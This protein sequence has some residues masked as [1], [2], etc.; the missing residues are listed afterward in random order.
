[1]AARR[2][3]V[4]QGR[5]GERR[6]LD[7]LLQ[8]VRGGRSAALVIRGEA[9][10]GKTALLRHC[11]R[12]ASG[13]HVA[14]IAGVESEMELAFAGLHQLCA[15]ML[16]R[17]DALAE[18]QQDA[19][20]VAL[21]L[22]SGDAPNRFLVALATLGL[23]AEEAADRPL[24]CVVDDAQW[25]DAASRQ[26]LGFV[27]RRLQAEAV[28]MV[29]AVRDP[30]GERDL[31]G[32]PELRLEGLPTEDARALLAAVIP[33]GLDDRV[34]DRL[35][36]ETRGN[37]LAIL[38]IPRALTPAQLPGGVGLDA[39]RPLSGRIEASFL[40]R[41]EALAPQ[42]RLLLLVAAAEPVGD[43]LLV[44]SAAERLGVGPSAAAGAET[45]GLLAIG[46]RVTFLHPL[47]RSAAYRAAP[48]EQRQAVHRA[49]AAAMDGEGD[50]DRR[51]WH[52][53]AAAR[54]PDEELA[55]E[56]ERSAGR[57]RARGGLAAAGAF[58]RR[59]GALTR[60]PAR[61]AER[62]LAAAQASLHAG[63]SEAAVA[64]LAAADAGPLDELQRARVELLRGQIASAAGPGG[65]APAQLLE[66]A[67][68]LEHLDPA[69]ARETYL[70]AW[71]AALFAGSL[72]AAGG[73]LL[74][75]SRAAIAGPR[76]TGPRR[77]ADELLD[78]LARLVVDGRAAAAPVLTRAV[79]AFLA[80]ETSVEKG[81]QWAVLASTAA[82]EVWDF[83]SWDAVLSRH[84]RVARDA[85][86]LAQLSIALNGAGIVVAWRGDVAAAARVV[87][88][89]DAITEA[90]GTRVAPYGAMLLAALGGRADER[91]G[92][93]EATLAEATAGEEGL[94]VQYAHWATA[95]LCNG[96]GRHEE[97]LAAAQRAG[98]VVPGLF[99]S[100][101]ALP[102][103]IE[104]AAGSGR[105]DLAADALR[106][107]EESASAG[108]T[109]WGLGIAARARALLSAGSA[110]EDA[111]REAIERLDRTPLRPEA[112]RA[113][114]LY[115]EWLCREQRRAAARAELTVAYDML[116]AMGVEG[117][118]E[119]AAQKL[120]A[121]GGSVRR[122]AH[123]VPDG[124]TPQEQ[125]IA[126]LARDGRT[127]SQIGAELF[128]S[129]RT[130]E[131]HL[132][133][134]FTKL[135]ITSRR[136]LRLALAGS[137]RRAR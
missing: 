48:V 5:A 77:P 68:R 72:A 24:L 45:E 104:A 51:A 117:F 103:L 81:L 78:G 31:A 116:V 23:L 109:D 64:V 86:A 121:A 79:E 27:G 122:P 7:R 132:N 94:A 40:R 34:R 134:V 58:L 15:P 74:D 19:L 1:M 9:G 130:V 49:L 136:G 80:S 124:L 22:S 26:A 3:P 67:R 89:A 131:W 50:A 2:S 73:G 63:A 13:L 93:I 46:E 10:V 123:H 125:L 85:G 83:E 53:A 92:L 101:W 75:V 17:L 84:V 102:E 111:H 118:A 41:L 14:E 126:R 120:V 55:A 39:A 107:L 137:A 97:A 96:L 62:A 25:L 133:K 95:V 36:A 61:R 29:F 127:N 115:G 11:T 42:T 69:L 105:P 71:G 76:P 18:P 129:P 20:R 88:E 98:E 16:G 60:D 6:E 57:A 43:P 90:T 128:L 99:I 37:P 119:R 135:G 70:D 106:R 59:S 32:L 91:R 113:H 33:S 54:E 47:V 108:G 112:A 30:G 110:A 44:W 100:Q 12:Q 21:G 28:G 66:A 82:V 114:L 65:Q 52:L 56:L 35:I 4:L 87:V 38:E 8:H